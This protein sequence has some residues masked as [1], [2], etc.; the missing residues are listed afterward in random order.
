MYPP[1]HLAVLTLHCCTEACPSGDDPNT[2]TRDESNCAYSLDNGATWHG[3]RYAAGTAKAGEPCYHDPTG[4]TSDCDITASLNGYANAAALIADEGSKFG[5]TGNACYV[6]CS[7]RGTCDF[8]TGQCACFKGYRGA[9]CG[10]I[11]ARA[12]K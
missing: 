6:P 3:A 12:G 5:A 2:L 4:S 7:N 10:V 8:S 1:R 11:D 9:N